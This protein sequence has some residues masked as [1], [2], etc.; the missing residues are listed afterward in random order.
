MK[1]A[2]CTLLD[3]A[4]GYWTGSGW[5]ITPNQASIFD[6]KQTPEQLIPLLVEKEGKGALEP[7]TPDHYWIEEIC[8]ENEFKS[9]PDTW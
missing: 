4:V 1:Y 9:Q 6:D 8:D 2:L 3:M 5:T 7:V